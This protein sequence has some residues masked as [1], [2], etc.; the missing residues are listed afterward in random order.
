MA[1]MPTLSLKN[2]KPNAAKITPIVIFEKSGLNKNESP[3][4]A[5]GSVND[6]ISIITRRIKSRGIKTLVTRSIPL[7]TPAIIIVPITSKT[8]ICQNKGSPTPDTSVLKTRVVS[9]G[10]AES[11]APPAA[12]KI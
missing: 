7:V 12:L 2:A 6:R 10:F 3:S 11:S 9:S 8:N 1:P 5:P 4:P